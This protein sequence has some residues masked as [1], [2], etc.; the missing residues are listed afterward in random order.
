MLTDKEIELCRT[1]G[2]AATTF[3]DIATETGLDDNDVREF[4]DHVHALQNAVMAQAARRAHPGV[5]R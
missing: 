3:R 1:L 2:E 5:F 4:I